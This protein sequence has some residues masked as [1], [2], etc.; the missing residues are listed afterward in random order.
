MSLNGSRRRPR[1]LR[2]RREGRPR[3]QTTKNR[4]G[5]RTPDRYRRANCAGLTI[6]ACRTF[7]AT[8]GNVDFEGV[9]QVS[10]LF[11][12]SRFRWGPS[13]VHL[14]DPVALDTELGMV[15]ANR[16]RIRGIQDTVDSVLGRVEQNI[17]MR[18]AEHVGGSVLEFLQ[19]GGRYRPQFMG[20]DVLWHLFRDSPRNAQ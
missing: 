1:N 9:N 13:R 3:C 12:S 15:F 10:T 8:R 7:P 16:L 18:N 17:V 5:A 4:D 20:I 6:E 2:A 14:V 11:R 19:V